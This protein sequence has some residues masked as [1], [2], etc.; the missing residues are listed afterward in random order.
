MPR[1]CECV[2]AVCVCDLKH[3]AEPRVSYFRVR[4]HSPVLHGSPSEPRVAGSSPPSPVPPIIHPHADNCTPVLCSAFRVRIALVFVEL[5]GTP[6]PPPS[7][8]LCASIL[9]L[10]VCVCLKKRALLQFNSQL[11]IKLISITDAINNS[12]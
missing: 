9:K 3:E 7:P 1:I 10:S 6:S 12:Y 4:V 2:C 5:V 11:Q 8:P